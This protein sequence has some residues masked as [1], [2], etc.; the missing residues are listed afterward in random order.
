[1]NEIAL[2]RRITKVTRRLF[3]E[4]I[5]PHLFRD[6]AATSIA[7]EDPSHVRM[8]AAILGHSSLA[9]TEAYYNQAKAIEAGRLHQQ[10]IAALRKRFGQTRLPRQSRRPS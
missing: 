10:N 3:G 1:M 4:A 6:A 2:Y 7:I 9:T 5:N 8:A